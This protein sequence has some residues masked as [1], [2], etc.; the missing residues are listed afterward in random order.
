MAGLL[1]RLPQPLHSGDEPAAAAPVAS[2]ALARVGG[3]PPPRYAAR[4]GFVPR[5]PAD[6]G[7]G[8]A[9]PECHVAQYPLDCGRKGGAGAG[10]KN[11]VVAVTVAEDG[12]VDYSALV[13][14]GRAAKTVVHTGHGALVP[15]LHDM[16]EEV[17]RRGA[18]RRARRHPGGR[19]PSRVSAGR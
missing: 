2:Q 3:P 14:Q 13:K 6:F 11:G 5:K 17:R 9:Y 1:G 16:T 8:G 15:K 4:A 10:G 19:V 12:S 18:A 7:D